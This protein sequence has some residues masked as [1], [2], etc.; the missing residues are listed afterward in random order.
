MEI[1]GSKHGV[2]CKETGAY[3]IYDVRILGAYVYYDIGILGA[4]VTAMTSWAM[5]SWATRTAMTSW[6]IR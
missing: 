4:Y 6:A 5:T 2:I 3:V 1:Q